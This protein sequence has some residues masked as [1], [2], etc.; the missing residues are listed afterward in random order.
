[1]VWFLCE[2]LLQTDFSLGRSGP[3]SYSRG[4]WARVNQIV[5]LR[6]DSISDNRA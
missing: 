2:E 1:M 6:A 4:K 5:N 3:Y